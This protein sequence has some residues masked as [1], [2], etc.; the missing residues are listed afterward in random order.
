MN[1]MKK[2]FQNPEDRYPTQ[3]SDLIKEMLVAFGIAFVL[4]VGLAL[5]FRTPFTPPVTIKETAQSDPLLFERTDMRDLM[6]T[7]ALATYGPPYNAGPAQQA[8]GWFAPEQWGGVTNAITTSDLYVLNILRAAS[9]INPHIIPLIDVYTAAASPQQQQWS[10]NYYAALQNA[11]VIDGNVIVPA[12][13][14]GPVQGMMQAM[15]SI[16]QSGFM[17]SALNR[18]T[19]GN[20]GVYTY[21]FSRSILFLQGEALTNKATAAHLL[22]SDWGIARE[23]GSYPGPWWL[24]IYTFLYQIPPYSTASAGDLLV[25]LTMLGVFLVIMLLP[26]IP[27]LNK[28]PYYIP[29]YKVIWRRWYARHEK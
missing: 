14:Y 19:P 20:N 26:F 7:S 15:L 10:Q 8:I 18:T 13:D 5:I 28:I 11:H 1:S 17:D 3:P 16:A 29:I 2:T 4:I 6:G 24:M 23:E 27:G 22:G 9:P 25:V 12:G 21:N